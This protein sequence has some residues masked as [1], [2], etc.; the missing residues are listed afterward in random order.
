[1][2]PTVVDAPERTVRF[3]KAGKS[4]RNPG[5]YAAQ[6]DVRR[7]EV[8]CG[9]VGKAMVRLTPHDSLRKR[10]QVLRARDIIRRLR[11]TGASGEVWRHGSQSSRGTDKYKSQNQRKGVSL[12]SPHCHDS[13]RPHYRSLTLVHT[14][15]RQ[16]SAKQLSSMHRGG[17]LRARP[18]EF[19]V[20]PGLRAAASLPIDIPSSN[21]IPFSEK[22]ILYL[23]IIIETQKRAGTDCK[24][25]R[26]R[27]KISRT[28]AVSGAGEQ[29]R[30][31]DLR[32]TSALLYP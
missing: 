24:R 27:E 18:Q 26:V 32:I 4:Y 9:T 2:S 17:S 3:L 30:T 15:Q 12:Q 21:L 7:L 14:P 19:V 5:R 29:I 20:C 31:V 16:K 28:L 23:S 10:G 13:L 8:V 6:V 25:K 22:E 1:M 11:G